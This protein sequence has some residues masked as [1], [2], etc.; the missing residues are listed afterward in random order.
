MCSCMFICLCLNPP[1]KDTTKSLANQPPHD[2][3][4]LPEA[5]RLVDSKLQRIFLSSDDI[6]RIVGI[7]SS[8][9]I[10]LQVLDQ[11]A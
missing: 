8:R 3:R 9:D 2:P 11:L 7:V 1:R 5:R 10:M 6:A 4:F